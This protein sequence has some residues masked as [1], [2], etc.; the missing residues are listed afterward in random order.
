MRALHAVPLGVASAHGLVDLCVPRKFLVLYTACLLPWPLPLAAE[1]TAF[2]VASVCHFAYDVG[3]RGSVFFHVL[4]A[5]LHARGCTETA[6]GIFIPFYTVHAARV[7]RRANVHPSYALALT[8]ASV[9]GLATRWLLRTE[10]LTRMMMRIVVAHVGVDCLSRRA[11][12]G[13]T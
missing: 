13:R 4:L 12:H 11:A 6:R 8:C 1:I 2:G 7:T 10:S 3:W 9:A 5:I